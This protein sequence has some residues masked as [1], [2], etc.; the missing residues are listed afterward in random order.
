M[1]LDPKGTMRKKII[2]NMIYNSLAANLYSQGS[3]RF[4][5]NDYAGALKSFETQIIITES[6]KFAGAVDTGMYYNAGLAAINSSK[7]NEA[8]KYFEKCAE[9]KYLGR[10]NSD[11]VKC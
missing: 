8:I 9:M 6:D 7:Y 11:R 1:Q 5:A 2:S 4:E 10:I 3:I